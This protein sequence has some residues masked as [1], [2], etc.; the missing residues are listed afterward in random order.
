M[1]CRHQYEGI[2]GDLLG[3]ANEMV[4]IGLLIPLAFSGDTILGYAGWTWLIQ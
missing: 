2:T 3:T 4:V 1:R